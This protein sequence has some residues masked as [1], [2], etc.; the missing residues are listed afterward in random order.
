[1]LSDSTV[2]RIRFDRAMANMT[3]WLFFAVALCVLA[4]LFW[5]GAAWAQ[6][7]AT[8]VA[9]STTATATSQPVWLTLVLQLGPWLISGAIALYL[10]LHV[11]TWLKADSKKR[12]GIVAAIENEAGIVADDVDAYLSKNGQNLKDLIDPT[13]RAAAEA[14]LVADAKAQASAAVDDAIKRSL[15][16]G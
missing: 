15:P 13:K 4:L 5:A 6:P 7:V 8:S 10:S 1:M 3:G 11:G 12:T 9:T 2:R 16:V 14:A